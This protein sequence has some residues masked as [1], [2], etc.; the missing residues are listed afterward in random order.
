MYTTLKRL[1]TLG[2]LTKEQISD[3]TKYEWITPEQY[4]DITGEEYVDESKENE[5]EPLA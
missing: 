4:K 3:S 2:M 1:Y 5:P